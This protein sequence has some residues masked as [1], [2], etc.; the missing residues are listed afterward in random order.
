LSWLEIIK[1][2]RLYWQLWLDPA[3]PEVHPNV[4]RSSH[5]N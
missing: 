3:P 5:Q 1:T 4:L 2:Y